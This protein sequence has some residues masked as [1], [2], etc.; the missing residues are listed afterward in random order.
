[1]KRTTKGYLAA[2][3]ISIPALA[4][5]APIES[6]TFTEIVQDVSIFNP[7][8]RLES[9]PKVGDNLPPGAVIRTGVNSRTE[10]VA[11]DNTVTRIGSNTVFSVTPNTR[12]VSLQKGSVLFHSPTGK[13]GGN[14]N[15][16]G[17][18]A[19]VLGT[20][21]IVGT[22]P[23]G[24]FK[25]MLLEGK[26]KVSQKGSPSVTLNAGQLSF[27]LP[28]QSPSAPLNFG[29]RQ[30]VNSSKLLN[31][32]SKPVASIAKIEAAIAKQQAKLE[33]GDISAT[34]LL[35]GD[36]PTTA[37]QIDST[38]I[39]I[40]HQE[41]QKK[42]ILA[43]RSTPDPTYKAA[44]ATDLSLDTLNPPSSQLF[45]IDGS[46]FN[47]LE[48]F[49]LPVNIPAAS[50][51]TNS[52]SLLIGNNLTFGPTGDSRFSPSPISGPRPFS[53]AAMVSLNT[54]DIQRSI[55]FFTYPGPDG[56][57]LSPI[58]FDAGNTIRIS[59]GVALSAETA[60][61]RLNAHGSAYANDIDL[62]PLPV[63]GGN[64]P[65]INWDSIAL[66]NIYSVDDASPISGK[67]VVTAP[68][69]SL[70]NARVQ[71]GHLLISV[72]KDLSIQRTSNPSTFPNGFSSKSDLIL[73]APLIQ[74]ISSSGAVSLNDIAMETAT[75]SLS[76]GTN[77]S[78]IDTVIAPPTDA[79][80][81]QITVTAK[82]SVTAGNEPA[83]ETADVRR[84]TTEFR[85]VLTA[86]KVQITATGDIALR[87]V[88]TRADTVNATSASTLSLSNVD[89]SSAQT[90]ALAANTVVLAD[91]QF[92][93]GSTV[94]LKS[95]DGLVAPDP[96]NG[97]SVRNG[98]V[99]FVR[100][101]FYGETE[102]KF[103]TGGNSV[104]NAGF[105]QAATNAG[106]NLSGI[107]IGKK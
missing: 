95:R 66:Q 37:Y 47:P 58:L 14:I 93:G 18:T 101:V 49:A 99:N 103:S 65:V 76:A 94:S 10:L 86:K 7:T 33:K 53:S 16:A 42:Q 106:K 22:T 64:D 17:V 87:G 78:V 45:S 91:T 3:L 43:D 90:V 63:T 81:S 36:S 80:T 1:M 8:S 75:L 13:G 12:D 15:T 88:T 24:G 89:L 38:V 41:V 72:Q 29:L 73:S 100:N 19:S 50:G 70:T 20:T 11:H 79:T 61:W 96:G 55:D 9:R 56:N 85:T 104:N 2:F 28:G 30:Q 69:L 35:I 31:G 83:P 32:F 44:V 6:L 107:T 71:A 40:I 25:T 54:I 59:P 62:T 48:P 46:G 39:R 84:I 27:A 5:C 102:I 21:L 98:M 52:F 34:G 57:P 60:E 4:L 77:V 51:S 68:S 105:Q 23:N 92:K 82:G 74:L 26:G 97:G 67:I